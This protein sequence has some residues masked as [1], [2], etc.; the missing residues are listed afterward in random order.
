MKVKDKISD[1]FIFKFLIFFF[2]K[3]LTILYYICVFFS[4]LGNNIKIKFIIFK[5]GNK[6]WNLNLINLILKQN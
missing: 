3:I 1:I 4:M 5:K 6:Q 2:C